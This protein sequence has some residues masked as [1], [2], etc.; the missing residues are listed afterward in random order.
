MDWG[1]YCNKFSS[2]N[3][4]KFFIDQIIRLK[5]ATQFSDYI[6]QNSNRLNETHEVSK[7]I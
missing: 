6:S 4:I 5:D 2:Y 7:V 3:E 1:E